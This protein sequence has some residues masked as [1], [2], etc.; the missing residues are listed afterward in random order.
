MTI[1]LLCPPKSRLRPPRAAYRSAMMLA[2]TIARIQSD[3]ERLD[4]IRSRGFIAPAPRASIAEGFVGWCETALGQVTYQT[5]RVY[6]TREAAIEQC[7]KYRKQARSCR[8]AI[9]T[10]RPD[11]RVET[12]GKGMT[13]HWRRDHVA[14]RP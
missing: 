4:R 12:S 13:R 11:G 6:P 7:F 8:T 10:V 9:G 3:G 5:P 2:D 1:D 14:V